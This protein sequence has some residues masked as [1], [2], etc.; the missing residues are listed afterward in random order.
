[1]VLTCSGANTLQLFVLCVSVNY[2]QRPAFKDCPY[3]YHTFYSETE[4]T[5]N[6]RTQQRDAQLHIMISN[7][8]NQNAHP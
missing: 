4:N 2:W 8:H 3:T 1:M 7:M 5:C 6:Q